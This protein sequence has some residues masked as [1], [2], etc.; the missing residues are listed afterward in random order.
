MRNLSIT[1]FLFGTVL[2]F[3]QPAT[4]PSST[5]AQQ[6]D[7][8]TRKPQTVMILTRDFD[9]GQ[10]SGKHIHHGVE[11]AIIIKGDW[12]ITMDGS[13]PR[14]YHAGESVTIPRDVPHD[15]KNVGTTTATL[16]ITFVIDKGSPMRIPVP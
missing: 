8:P 12:Q 14:V 16:A 9:P 4:A 1:A 11:M 10:S 5:P 15:G 3:A 13:A 7:V 2:A 6:Y